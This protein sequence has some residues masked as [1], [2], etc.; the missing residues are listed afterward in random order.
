MTAAK[1]PERQ[2]PPR[3]PDCHGLLADTGTQHC[4]K[5]NLVC[6]WMRCKCGA[7]I[8]QTGAW[9]HGARRGDAA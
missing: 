1:P 4:P 7:V 2:F 3:C 5:D 6:D 9:T 8:A